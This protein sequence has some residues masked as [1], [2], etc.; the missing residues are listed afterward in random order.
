V[1]EVGNL[2]AQ[3]VDVN[4]K[5]GHRQTSPLH[6][7]AQGH[8]TEVVKLLLTHGADTSVKDRNQQ[9]PLHYIIMFNRMEMLFI[10]LEHGVEVSPRD[11]NGFTP[12]HNAV[13]NLVTGNSTVQVM[14]L[15]ENGADVDLKSTDGLTPLDLAAK[16]GLRVMVRLL[17]HKGADIESDKNVFG[18]NAEGIA[19]LNGNVEVAVILRAEAERLRVRRVAFAMGLHDRLGA[20]SIV[21]ALDPEVVRLVLQ[22]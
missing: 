18:R 6:E 15:L 10:F 3:G 2:L 17:I 22:R 9:A 5:G 8:W 1:Q 16:R 21:R 11:M 13:D 12:L 14:L 19:T 4:A 20:G 7:A